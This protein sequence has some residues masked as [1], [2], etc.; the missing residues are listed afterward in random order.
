MSLTFEQYQTMDQACSN[1]LQIPTVR[2][3]V[4]INHLGRLVAGE[5][6]NEVNPYQSEQNQKMMFMELALET[7]MRKE[8]NNTLG[9]LE[10]TVSSRDRVLIITIPLHEQLVVIS[11]EPESDFQHIARKAFDQFKHCTVTIAA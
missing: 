2:F 9:D 4:V 6:K 1:V 10:Y 5:F 8:Y 3:C 7:R 11:A